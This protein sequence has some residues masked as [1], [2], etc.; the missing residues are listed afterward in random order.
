MHIAIKPNKFLELMAVARI[1]CFYPIEYKESYL[2]A[3]LLPFGIL[4]IPN[5]AWS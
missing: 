3:P 4:W 2:F 5:S 1:S